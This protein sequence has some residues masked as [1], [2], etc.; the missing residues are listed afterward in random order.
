MG[1]EGVTDQEKREKAIK[2]LQKLQENSGCECGTPDCSSCPYVGDKT[3][4][5]SIID[6]AI[7]L[8]KA[9]EPVK[10]VVAG[11]ETH[12]YECECGTGID[13]RDFYCRGCG[14]AVKWDG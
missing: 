13:Y 11:K 1:D 4:C 14:R 7:E 3:C 12:W 10:P 6:D 2:G 8:L 5:K 9:Q